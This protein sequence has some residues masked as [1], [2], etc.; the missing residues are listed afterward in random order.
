M[1]LENL[2]V[3]PELVRSEN[4]TARSRRIW[5][6]ETVWFGPMHAHDTNSPGTRPV[7][8]SADRP[9]DALA[10]RAVWKPV[11]GLLHRN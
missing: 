8:I 11:T 10:D 7:P 6:T 1:G 5:A 4:S 9:P 3:D 2:V